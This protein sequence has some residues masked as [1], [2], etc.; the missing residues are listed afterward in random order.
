[1]GLNQI[2][3]WTSFG[4]GPVLGL[5]QFWVGPVLGSGQFWGW[6]SF[7]WAS[8]GLGQFWVGPVFTGQLWVGQLC[9][10][11]F[12]GVILLKRSKKD[13]IFQS[14]FWPPQIKNLIIGVDDYAHTQPLQNCLLLPT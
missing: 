4:I 3:N 6:A 14:P 13:K 10:G 1:M 8:F 2:W 5:G 12:W 9:L 11:Q 7:G